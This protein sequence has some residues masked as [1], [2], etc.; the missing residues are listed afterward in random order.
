MDT[1]LL[2]AVNIFIFSIGLLCGWFTSRRLWLKTYK[3][4]QELDEEYSKQ[5][6]IDIEHLLDLLRKVSKRKGK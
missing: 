6:K 3:V 5:F 2:V 1:A 4:I